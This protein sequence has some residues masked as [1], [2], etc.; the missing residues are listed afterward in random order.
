VPTL[1][2]AEAIKTPSDPGR[3]VLESYHL[4][5]LICS[6][7]QPV[8]MLL[9]RTLNQTA[10]NIVATKCYRLWSAAHRLRISSSPFLQVYTDGYL[11]VFSVI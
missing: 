3:S 4:L 7:F 5:S 1:N 10:R 8:A 9:S 6:S 2:L 11:Y